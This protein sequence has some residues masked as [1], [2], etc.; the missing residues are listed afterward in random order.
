M[1]IEYKQVGQEHCA[2]DRGYREGKCQERS[3][4]GLRF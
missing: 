1:I 4:P 3:A 2:P